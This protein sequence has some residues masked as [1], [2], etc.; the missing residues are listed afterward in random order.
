MT[1]EEVRLRAILA[2]RTGDV[3]YVMD[4]PR[5]QQYAGLY[6]EIMCPFDING[7]MKEE[8][9]LMKEKEENDLKDLK[10]RLD[11]ELNIKN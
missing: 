2:N 6:P 7:N 9:K 1:N 4:I 3:R 8:Y 10:E 5:W 11:L